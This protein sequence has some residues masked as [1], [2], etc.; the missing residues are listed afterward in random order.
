MSFENNFESNED[1]ESIEER[2]NKQL[3]QAGLYIESG[4]KQEAL[5][6][7]DLAYYVAQQESLEHIKDK[8]DVLGE[9]AH[10]LS[11]TVPLRK[12]VAAEPPFP[13]VE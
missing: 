2:L 1:N 5:D 12:S 8:I 4:Q 7:L 13:S 3:E 10:S 11:D 6:E 9:R